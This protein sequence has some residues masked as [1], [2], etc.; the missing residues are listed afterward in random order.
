VQSFTGQSGGDDLFWKTTGLEVDLS[1]AL[2][3]SVN[4]FRQ[5]I[6]IQHMNEIYAR[7]GS[8]YPEVMLGHFGVQSEDARLQR[9]ELLGI[10]ST[11]MQI[12]SVPQTEATAGSYAQGSLAAFGEVQFSDKLFTK[13]FTEHGYIMIILSVVGDITYSQGIDKLWDRS[14][15]DDFYWPSFNGIGEQVVASKEIYSDGSAGDA[16]VF[17]Y[18]ER[19]AEYRYKSSHVTSL[20]RPKRSGNLAAWHL[21]EE[22]STRPTLGN[23]FIESNTPMD[24]A[25]AV[26][27]EPHFIA[28]VYIQ[29][30]SARAM[31]VFSNPGLYRI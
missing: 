17:C 6:A 4:E 7:S 3:P 1:S 12:N 20:F 27:S 31:P 22:F 19:F 15:K 16:D 5:A 26:T 13:S 21:S 24:R 28:D 25:I 11:F 9:P 10:G 29:N 30:K 23:T 8:R 18:Q 2:A 14:T